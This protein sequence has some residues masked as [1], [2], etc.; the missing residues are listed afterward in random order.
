MSF[1]TV[2]LIILYSFCLNFQLS[3]LEIQATIIPKFPNYSGKTIPGISH[4]YSEI[5]CGHHQSTKPSF[6]DTIFPCLFPPPPPRTYFCQ[7]VLRTE[8][9]LWT[10]KVKLILQ[11]VQKSSSLF[12]YHFVS[13]KAWLSS[14]LEAGL[15]IEVLFAG[16]ICL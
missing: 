5:L 1:L 9:L 6:K 4:P 3:F 8:N 7:Y 16:L 14:Y 10:F 15:A 11:F 12:I 13:R 2:L